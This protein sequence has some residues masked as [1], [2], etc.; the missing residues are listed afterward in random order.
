MLLRHM[1]FDAKKKIVSYLESDCGF[2]LNKRLNVSC[3][4]NNNL[5][6]QRS[7]ESESQNL[8]FFNLEN[9]SGQTL[10]Q[11]EPLDIIN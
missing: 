9:K 2:H 3:E 4:N 6:E 7:L 1:N 11:K 8:I 10:F 5:S